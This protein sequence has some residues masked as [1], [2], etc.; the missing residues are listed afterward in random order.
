MLLLV[1]FLSNLKGILDA[2]TQKF[3][4]IGMKWE[5][6][7]GLFI[8]RMLKVL[9]GFLECTTERNKSVLFISYSR[10]QPLYSLG[11]L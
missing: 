9:F 6:G 8:P 11:R 10:K 5:C 1:E 3:C 2:F 7:M 4:S